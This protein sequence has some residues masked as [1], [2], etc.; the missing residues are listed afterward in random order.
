[1]GSMESIIVLAIV[2]G[3]PRAKQYLVEH[4]RSPAEVEAMPVAQVIILYTV[5]RHEE[6]NDD[7]FKWMFLPYAASKAGLERSAM[8]VVRYRRQEI[9]HF[10]PL[11]LAVQAAKEAETRCQWMLVLLQTCEALRIY[12]AAHD[13][14]LPDRLS[15]IRE[16]PVPVNPYDDKPLQY[17]RDGNRAVLQAEHGPAYRRDFPWGY[18]ITMLPRAK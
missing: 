6:L 14:Q 2:Q 16:V 17:H 18:E 5:G 9:L 13:G 12:A 10:S 1:M 8:E 15:D 7:Q 11:I 4:G 3:Y